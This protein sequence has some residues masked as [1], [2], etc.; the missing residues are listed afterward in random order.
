MTENI[1]IEIWY[2]ND[3]EENEKPFSILIN[4]NNNIENGN[5]IDFPSAIAWSINT[6]K[7][8][9]EMSL[10]DISYL[11][12][13]GNIFYMKI[14]PDHRGMYMAIYQTIDING[15]NQGDY[16]LGTSTLNSIINGLN[17]L[18]SEKKNL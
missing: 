2:R 12:N 3:F 14:F 1:T 17:Y 4:K 7:E 11:N 18:N 15:N 16:L 5:A 8:K 6:L 13:L 9:Y 10:I